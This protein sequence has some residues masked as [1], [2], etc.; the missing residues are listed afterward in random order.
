M[1]RITARKAGL[2]RVLFDLRREIQEEIRARIRMGRNDEPEEGRDHLE[3][4]DADFRGGVELALLQMKA[5][6]LTRIDEALVR[7]DAGRY[8][9]C[10]EC[11]QEISERRLR[12]LPFAVRCQACERH[13]EER[14]DGRPVAQR[15]SSLELFR[16]AVG[17]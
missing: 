14:R 9:S 11:E 3:Q 5:E 1:T 2:R 10:V 15:Y 12:A 8:G 7:L 4:S 17:S 16:D 13:R 6:T